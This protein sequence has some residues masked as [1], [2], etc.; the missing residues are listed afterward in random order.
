MAYNFE[1]PYT[2]PNF[3]NDDWLLNK[4]KELLSDMERIDE[5]TKEFQQAYEELMKMIEDLENGTFPDYIQQAFYNWMKK[6]AL[7][8]IG[9]MAKMVFFGLNDDGYWVAYIPES[10][11]DIVFNTTDLDIFLASYP[12]Y[13]RLVLSMKIGGA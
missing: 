7:N 2:D 10:W 1:F 8:I 11:E 13:G 9:E 6:N 5:W 4:M 12:E 3:Y